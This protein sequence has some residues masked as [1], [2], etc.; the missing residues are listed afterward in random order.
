MNLKGI[1]CLKPA[2]LSGMTE[3]VRSDID[4]HCRIMMRLLAIVG[5]LWLPFDGSI[6]GGPSILGAYKPMAQVS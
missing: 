2:A 4:P 5:C 6:D 1:V 3:A